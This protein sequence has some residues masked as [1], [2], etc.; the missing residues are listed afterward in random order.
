MMSVVS[1][2]ISPVTTW[3]VTFPNVV[4]CFPVLE[5]TF[6]KGPGGKKSKIINWQ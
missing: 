4:S 3:I 5:V 1:L 2:V 6:E